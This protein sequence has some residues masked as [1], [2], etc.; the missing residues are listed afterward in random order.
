MIVGCRVKN[1][2]YD[3]GNVIGYDSDTV[4]D[5][6]YNE[7]VPSYPILVVLPNYKST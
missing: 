6:E 3:E 2:T 5:E 7:N 4:N 1:V